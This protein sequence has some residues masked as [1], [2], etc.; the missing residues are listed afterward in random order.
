[1]SVPA[2]KSDA[3]SVTE[4][5]AAYAAAVNAAICK[6]LGHPVR[7]KI[8]V[9]LTRYEASPS[10]IAQLSGESLDIVSYHV[11]EMAK[12]RPMLIEHVKNEPG[13]R[14]GLMKV[15]KAC[16]R[17]ILWV[18]SW[19]QLPQLIRET[20][21]VNVAEMVVADLVEAINEG[22]FDS[23]P[24]RTLIQLRGVVDEAGWDE[25]EPAA[26]RW[27]E[28]LDGIM[29]R[30]TDRMATTKEAGINISAAT[31]AFE[32]PPPSRRLSDVL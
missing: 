7:S 4:S 26:E 28:D 10:E 21:S 11:R 3:T 24:G 22:T 17:P 31:L 29:A 6:A 23:R 12:V 16:V 20:N 15:Y 1:M 27:L 2:T 30:S 9:L 25:L 19:E 5:K 32:V 18:E 14:G 13:K 8:M